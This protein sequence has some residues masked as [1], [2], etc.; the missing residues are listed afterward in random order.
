MGLKVAE[1][2]SQFHIG[3]ALYPSE[4]DNNDPNED[5]LLALCG[6]FFRAFNTPVLLFSAITPFSITL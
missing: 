2:I 1:S 4:V 6:S 3:K 5:P